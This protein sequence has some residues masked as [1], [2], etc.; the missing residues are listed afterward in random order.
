MKMPPSRTR[1]AMTAILRALFLEKG[2]DI[3]AEQAV[4]GELRPWLL[5]ELVGDHQGRSLGDRNL[6]SSV[7][8]ALH[9]GQHREVVGQSL[10]SLALLRG[11]HAGH[12]IPDLAG[13]APGSL[14]AEQSVTDRLILADARGSHGDGRG[15]TRILV[16]R[17]VERKLA[18]HQER[19][20]GLHVVLD[21]RRQ[22]EVVQ[23]FAGRAGEVAVDLKQYRGGGVAH[24]STFIHV[25]AGRQ[26]RQQRGRKER[27]N[28]HTSYCTVTYCTVIWRAASP[29]CS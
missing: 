12:D 23:V 26:A 27:E 18:E 4:V 17:N 11:E 25:G 16:G 7:H 29:P 9:I 20:A 21:Y 1:N 15:R 6:L 22:H 28:L 14:V 5:P 2:I 3:T 24:G 13:G 19:L 8:I 10:H